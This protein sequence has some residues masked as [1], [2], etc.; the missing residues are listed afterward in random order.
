MDR[1]TIGFK[2]SVLLTDKEILRVAN[3]VVL[4]NELV[5]AGLITGDWWDSQKPTGKGFTVKAAS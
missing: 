2:K 1:V 3:L 4:V 5:T